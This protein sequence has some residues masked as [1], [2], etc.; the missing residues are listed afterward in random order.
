MG[1]CGSEA[2]G[3]GKEK[4]VPQEIDDGRTFCKRRSIGTRK[5]LH[6]V[7]WAFRKPECF[8]SGYRRNSAVVSAE[9]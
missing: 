3:R 2:G 9:A 5:G 6:L 7:Q 1:M 4:S 8:G